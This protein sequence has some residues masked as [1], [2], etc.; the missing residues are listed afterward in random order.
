MWVGACTL[1]S[2]AGTFDDVSV[3]VGGRCMGASMGAGRFVAWL[4]T[5]AICI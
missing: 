3:L 2:G 4:R 1:C 5:C